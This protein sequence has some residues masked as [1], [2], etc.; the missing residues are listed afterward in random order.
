MDLHRDW[1]VSNEVEQ[2]YP[3]ENKNTQGLT[4]TKDL[5]YAKKATLYTLN[6]AETKGT[7]RSVAAPLLAKGAP[8]SSPT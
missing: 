7:Q 4:R 2:T 3:L 5:G 1:L 8:R 6:R